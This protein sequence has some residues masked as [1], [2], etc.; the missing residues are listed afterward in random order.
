MTFQW[1]EPPTDYNLAQPAHC[2]W[3]ANELT[4]KCPYGLRAKDRELIRQA[5]DA[6]AFHQ[7]P[8]PRELVELVALA[9]KVPFD[10]KKRGGVQDMELFRTAARLK[11]ETGLKGRTLAR[12][13]RARGL[14]ISDRTLDSWEK[15]RDW[16]AKGASGRAA[17]VADFEYLVRRYS[18][19]PDQ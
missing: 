6:C 10:G 12:E 11:A 17:L 2:V 13:L 14:K 9:L 7:Y 5:L 18:G 1:S 8:P 3:L 19:D 16:K 15:V 4:R